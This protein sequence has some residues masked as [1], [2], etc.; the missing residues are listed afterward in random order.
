MSNAAL[1]GLRNAISSPTMSLKRQVGYN[2]SESSDMSSRLK[3]LKMDTEDN[4][5]DD[6]L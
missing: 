6:N 3:R 1:D 5:M 4:D 2:D